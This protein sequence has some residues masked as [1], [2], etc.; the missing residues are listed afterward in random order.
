M[1]KDILCAFGVDV[2]AVAGWLGS[3]GG[4]D[5]PDDI[6]RGLF[7]GEVGAPRLLKMFAEQNLR[8]TWFIPGHSIETFP[9]QMKAVVDAGHEVGIHGYSHE[10]PIA[11]TPAQE[12]AVL[13]R[14]IELVTKLAGKRPTGYVAP[15]WEFS[16]VTNE[17]LLKKGIKYDHSL[18]HNDFHPYYV[19]VGDSWTKI[20]YSQHPDAWMKPLQR[21][22]E[23]D[24]VE[25]PAN[26]YLDDLP[27][28]MFIKKSPNSHGFVN[29]R[30]LEEMWRDQF[31]WVYRENDYAVFTMTIHPDVSGRPQVLLMLERLIQYIRSHEGVRFVTFDEIADDFKAR[32][33]RSA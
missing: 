22:E 11:M 17:L 20:D 29:P 27:P 2:D 32:K 24:L 10:N 14:S 12:E 15:W 4:E 28:M 19:R 6:S 31:D 5:S 23:T 26:W 9:E 8:T 3:Y 7:A 1:A 30:H 25:I 13:D 21:G 16:N 33:P 18:M